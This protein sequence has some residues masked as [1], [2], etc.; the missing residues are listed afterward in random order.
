MLTIEIPPKKTLNIKY[1]VSDFNGT[2]AV[3]GHLKPGVEQL[4]NTLSKKIEIHIIT[5]DTFGLAKNQLQ[6][7][8]CKLVILDKDN[9]QKAKQEY[10]KSLGPE[11]CV[12]FGNGR[13]D[14]LMLKQAAL[15]IGVLLEE[16]I[17]KETLLTCD[18]LSKDIISALEL[19][20]NPLRIKATL[21]T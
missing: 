10:I 5:A 9:Q 6:N 14:A 2:L 21:R 12:A 16:G 18:I 4:L 19:L 8:N 11:S 7:I 15:G 13:N 3:D 1:L 20:L 17:A